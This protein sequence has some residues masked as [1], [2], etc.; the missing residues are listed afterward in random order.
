MGN[1]PYVKLFS[2]YNKVQKRRI[3][4]MFTNKDVSR[5]FV[6]LALRLYCLILCISNVYSSGGILPQR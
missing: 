6:V 4:A 1:I 5:G 3:V 2:F